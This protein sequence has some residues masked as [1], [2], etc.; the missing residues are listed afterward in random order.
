MGT[1]AG[2][3]RA[4]AVIAWNPTTR[5][6]RSG[7]VPLP[8]GFEPWLIKFD[9]VDGNADK[10]LADP[11]GYGRIEYAYHLMAR[12]AGLSMSECQLL[13]ENGRAHFMT[14]RFDR[15]PDGD[16]LH[17]QTLCALGHYDFNQAGGYDDRG[18]R[19]QLPP[20]PPLLKARHS[21]VQFSSFSPIV[22]S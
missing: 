22:L 18:H 2:G 20:Y 13:E 1:S 21:P 12:A 5:E 6:I 11:L 3:A 17:Q 9:G 19:P 16:K 8:A 15:T 4:K 7:P 10:E 14:R